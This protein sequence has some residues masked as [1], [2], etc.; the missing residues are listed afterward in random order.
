MPVG[1]D[2]FRRYPT[3]LRYLGS[4]WLTNSRARLP[5]YTAVL[6]FARLTTSEHRRVG[7]LRGPRRRATRRSAQLGYSWASAVRRRPPAV[8]LSQR[9]KLR[10]LRSLR[11]LTR[12]LDA[13]RS[14]GSR[15][16]DGGR[17]RPKPRTCFELEPAGGA[18]PEPPELP[19]A[20]AVTASSARHDR[21]ADD[22][23]RTIDKYGTFQE[24]QQ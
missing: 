11:P 10:S 19:R 7:A 13:L 4:T 9:V 21:C 6:L 22:S 3:M 18:A 5:N 1:R 15:A 8:T 14:Y 23:E 2:P 24:R 16:I 17:Q 12:Q 20:P